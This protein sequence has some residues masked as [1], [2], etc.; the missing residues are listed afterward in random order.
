MKADILF[1]II[2]PVYRVEDCLDRC[3]RSLTG[4]T[5]REI[6]II[7]VDD[8]S[9]DR[10]PALCDEYAKQDVRIRVIHKE[11]GGLSDARNTGLKEARGEYVLF[12]D[13]DDYIDP[14]ACHRLHPYTKF[15]C[16]IIV[17]DGAAEGGVKR[18]THGNVPSGQLISGKDYLK[19]ACRRGA[20]PMAAW[21]YGYRRTFLE[22]NGLYF[23]KSILHED[24]QFTPRAF[25]AACRVVESGVS[26]YHYVIRA[27]SITT[28]RDLRRNAVDLY[29][30]CLELREIYRTLEDKEL[31]ELLTDS[32]AVKYLSLFQ[33]GKLYQY[34]KDYLHKDFVWG[35]ARRFKTRCKALLYC[36][37]PRLY[38]SVNCAAKRGQESRP[39]AE[40]GK[41]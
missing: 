34:G 26:F 21:L 11:N 29:A 37:S 15:G 41:E 16:D 32:L 18:L 23:K 38:W 35:S 4:Q 40:S 31:K 5:Y 6:E 12:V 28:G 20:M 24:E 19:I 8:G 10:C 30:I 17:G 13:A 39:A 1:S 14:D 25:L 22:E 7:L 3:V 27:G 36:V 33:Q 9:P 2:V